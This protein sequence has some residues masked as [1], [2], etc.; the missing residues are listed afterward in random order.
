M[1]FRINFWH[2]KGGEL[3]EMDFKALDSEER[4]ENRLAK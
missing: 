2:V 3:V 4:V 1:S